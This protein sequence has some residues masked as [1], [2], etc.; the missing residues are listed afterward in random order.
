MAR[1]P[2]SGA[3]SSAALLDQAQLRRLL[4]PFALLDSARR[5][6][7]VVPMPVALTIGD[8]GLHLRTEDGA[9]EYACA[10][11]IMV[12]RG[13]VAVSL[14]ADDLAQAID[15]VRALADRAGLDVAAPLR[16]VVYPDRILLSSSAEPPREPVRHAAMAA[17]LA[18]AVQEWPLISAL[19][20]SAHALPDAAELRDV[21]A[22]S[23]QHLGAFLSGLGSRHTDVVLNELPAWVRAA[24]FHWASADGATRGRW[25]EQ[26]AERWADPFDAVGDEWE[27]FAVVAL[28]ARHAAGQ[29]IPAPLRDRPI[30]AA[31]LDSSTTF[32]TLPSEAA[33]ILRVAPLPDVCAARAAH[34]RVAAIADLAPAIGVE[35]VRHVA[36]LASGCIEASRSAPALSL[37]T[38][39]TETLLAGLLAAHA[40]GADEIAERCDADTHAAAA[41]LAERW[42][43][44]TAHAALVPV[45]LPVLETRLARA[46]A[47]PTRRAHTRR[48]ALGVV[49]DAAGY[50][51]DQ[52]GESPVPAPVVV[53]ARLVAV[54]VSALG[55]ATRPAAEQLA[56]ESE[57]AQLPSAA[58][59]LAA[60]EHTATLYCDRAMGGWAFIAAQHVFLW[61]RDGRF[62]ELAERLARADIT[63]QPLAV[64]PETVLAARGMMQE[65]AR[66]ARRRPG[67]FDCRLEQ[68]LDG[69]PVYRF[70]TQG[71]FRVARAHDVATLMPE[72]T[73]QVIAQAAGMLRRTARAD[74]RTATSDD[75]NPRAVFH[76]AVATVA[77]EREAVSLDD[78]LSGA[79]AAARLVDVAVNSATGSVGVQ[80]GRAQTRQTVWL[81]ASDAPAHDSAAPMHAVRV[82]SDILADAAVTVAA[83]GGAGGGGP[84]LRARADTTRQGLVLVNGAIAAVVAPPLERSYAATLAPSMPETALRATML[85]DGG[86]HV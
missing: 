38:V 10:G 27:R 60:T 6:R 59:L 65:A 78:I 81:G 80:T 69:E 35:H 31:L 53:P 55:R 9:I 14:S 74:A 3:A 11:D 18:H 33:T 36:R 34:P 70:G 12:D 63:A 26:F 2:E 51:L 44:A 58:F 5:A 52:L 4:H 79:R 13:A 24:A 57:P 7:G 50:A 64:A 85:V 28:A 15:Q 86:L 25:R 37:H 20:M 83:A 23:N 66:I 22:A 62:A 71:V 46:A 67:D 82:P 41:V 45:L 56:A 72:R 43:I 54:D 73:Q 47:S 17:S 42:P 76:T 84:T 1:A 39:A 68:D 16:A 19:A 77:A 61:E 48:A 30:V 49:L 21:D 8:G 75:A 32:A 40:P 29:P